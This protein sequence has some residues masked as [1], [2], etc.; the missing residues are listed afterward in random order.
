MLTKYT[1]LLVKLHG[2]LTAPDF[3]QTHTPSIYRCLAISKAIVPLEP[4]CRAVAPR[5]PGVS[6]SQRF[7]WEL[8]LEQPCCWHCNAAPMQSSWQRDIDS[9]VHLLSFKQRSHCRAGCAQRGW[10]DLGL[11]LE[12]CLVFVPGLGHV[13]ECH[14]PCAGDAELSQGTRAHVC[15]HSARTGG[16]AQQNLVSGGCYFHSCLVTPSLIFDLLTE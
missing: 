10:L 8:E 3:Q 4:Q 2:E 15:P 12:L 1:S 13:L 14:S 9:M 6:G 7:R 16:S 5:S 11:E